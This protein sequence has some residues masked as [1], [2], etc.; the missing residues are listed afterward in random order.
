MSESEST[1]TASAERRNTDRRNIGIEFNRRC[2][3]RRDRAFVFLKTVYLSDTNAFG[4][5]YFAKYF[6]WQGMARESFFNRVL[7]PDQQA[8]LASGIKLITAEAE[9]KY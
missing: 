6:E 1:N 2:Y 9:H 4:N 8:F 5:T 3:D 7:F